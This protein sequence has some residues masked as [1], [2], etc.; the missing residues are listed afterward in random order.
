MEFV[1]VMKNELMVAMMKMMIQ[2]QKYALLLRHIC[3]VGNMVHFLD[4]TYVGT[5]TIVKR[6]VLRI[7]AIGPVMIKVNVVTTISV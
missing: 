4:V 1:G 2:K 5:E 6:F 7:V 3:T